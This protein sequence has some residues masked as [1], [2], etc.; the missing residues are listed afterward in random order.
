MVAVR[1]RKVQ[2]GQTLKH[3][4]SDDACGPPPLSDVKRQTCCAQPTGSGSKPQGI[5]RF[6]EKRLI[7]LAAGSRGSW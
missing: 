5:L 4:F 6:T 3:G 1:S 7:L 2:V